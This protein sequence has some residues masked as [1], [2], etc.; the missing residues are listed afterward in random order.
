MDALLAL[1]VRT[2]NGSLYRVAAHNGG[3]RVWLEGYPQKSACCT[4]KGLS[5]KQGQPLVVT[6]NAPDV[7]PI[8]LLRTSSVVGIS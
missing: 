8:T 1:K 2:F 6:A 3:W 5:L 4:A 7:G